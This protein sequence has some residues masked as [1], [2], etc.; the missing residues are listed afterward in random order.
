MESEPAATS[1]IPTI[2]R[3]GGYT[4]LPNPAARAIAT[5]LAD[6]SDFPLT[7]RTREMI[8]LLDRRATAGELVSAAR[9]AALDETQIPPD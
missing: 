1:P 6:A 8:E 7:E 3:E 5:A 4:L 2:E 9:R